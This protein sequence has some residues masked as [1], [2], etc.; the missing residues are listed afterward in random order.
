M[1]TENRIIV[2]AELGLWNGKKNAYKLLSC[3]LRECFSSE[4]DAVW[5]VDS[6]MDLRA[7]VVHHDGTNYYLYRE[8]KGIS[9]TQF[10][11]LTDRILNGTLTRDY[12]NRTTRKIGHLAIELDEVLGK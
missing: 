12:L 11:N 3:D 2:I 8:L 10:E 5:N 1:R 9:D 4:Y 6:R 7:E